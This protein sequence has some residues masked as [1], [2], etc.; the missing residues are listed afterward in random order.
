MAYTSRQQLELRFGAQEIV[1]LLESLGD[2]DALCD[3]IRDADALID[4]YLGAVY[5]LPL[6]APVPALVMSLSADIARYRLWDDRAPSEVRRRYEDA[7]SMLKDIAKGV[8][9]LPASP[10]VQPT[11]DYGGSIAT[12]SRERTFT[13]ETLGGFVSGSG[14]SWPRIT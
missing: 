14:I 4:G 10:T 7:L 5:Q 12:T 3:I 13:D 11:T 6:V 1:E 8:V 9:R 2:E